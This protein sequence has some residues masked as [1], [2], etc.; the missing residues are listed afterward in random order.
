MTDPAPLALVDVCYDDAAAR[1][2][3]ACVVAESWSDAA[4]AERQ[5][6]ELHAVAPYVPGRFFERELPCI[7][8]VLALVDTRF[9]A[10][11]VDGYVT[12]DEQGSPG[13]GAH[14]HRALGEKVVVIGVAKN[15]YRESDFARAVVRGTSK[16]PLWVTSA[17]IDPETA[18]R[19]VASMH[20]DHR[21][22]TLLERV[23]HLAR[24]ID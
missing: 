8:A 24:G 5:I 10:V 3:A 22:P 7:L 23:D 1:A 13:L 19:L 17:G 18:A 20:G 4:P 2:R 16:R 15:P 14:L 9:E 12:L 6:A 21:I 11:V